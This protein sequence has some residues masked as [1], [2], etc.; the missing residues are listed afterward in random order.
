MTG[1][2]AYMFVYS[3][4]SAWF[5]EKKEL[6]LLFW[7]PLSLRSSLI[8]VPFQTRGS[9]V[10]F[11]PWLWL[12]WQAH[13]EK[14]RSVKCVCVC[15]TEKER[16]KEVKGRRLGAG[17]RHDAPLNPQRR[18]RN[19]EWAPMRRW[20]E[21]WGGAGRPITLCR[22]MLSL[23]FASADRQWTEISCLCRLKRKEL[24]CTHTLVLSN[25]ETHKP[26]V[27]FPS[28]PPQTVETKP[29]HLKQKTHFQPT[30]LTGLV[31]LLQSDWQASF[32][33]QPDLVR[34]QKSGK[35]VELL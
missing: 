3:S 25:T 18:D 14:E 27:L 19:D 9:S 26:T 34:K 30:G 1:S 31:C 11:D 29:R 17:Q 7:P 16:V 12:D 6:S 28:A 15:E 21:G 10:S 8:I 22:P 33:H 13:E 5:G 4:A 20:Q 24:K 32:S 35:Y 2:H 23:H